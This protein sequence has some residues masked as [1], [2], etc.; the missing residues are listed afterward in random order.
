MSANLPSVT[1]FAEPSVGGGAPYLVLGGDPSIL[2]GANLIT[3]IGR[4]CAAII[5]LGHIDP[6]E[7][8]AAIESTPEPAIPIA[9]MGNNELVRRDFEAP[10]L[11]A[12]SLRLMEL[13]FIPIWHR[14]AELP[15]I[16]E[17]GEREELTILRLAYSRDTQITAA[18]TPESRHLVEYPLLGRLASHRAQL[19]MLAGVDLLSRAHFTRTHA[20]K[21]CDSARLHVYEACPACGSSDLRE[22]TIV[23]HYRCGC[24][25]AESHFT[26]G[27]FL[28]CPKCHR[29][30]RHLGVDYG[31]PG[32]AVVCATCGATTSQP[33]IA[34]TCLDC[35]TITPAD[36]AADT[37]W[38]HYDLASDGIAAL[39]LGR[40]PRFDIA[41]ILNGH[42]HIYSPQE[43]RLLASHQ[44]MVSERYKRPFSVARIT[45]LNL[46][47]LLSKQGAVAADE[48]F[49]S[50]A[51]AVIA[52]L[53]TAD[54]VGVD[55][56]LS[57]VIGFPET[58]AKSVETII[59]RIRSTVRAN[60][61]N[62]FAL[63][64][65]IA[66]GDAII[67]LLEKD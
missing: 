14:L 13:A 30:L 52:D 10:G 53:R 33:S 31:K 23:H 39:R 41:P 24:Q 32:K 21:K 48:G 37:D 8:A 29:A 55:S 25:E 46:D 5:L 64:V 18:L 60:T 9:D 26:Q 42:T 63:G 19:E 58:P 40:L 2:P 45:V 50:V 43:F 44:V 3:E 54:F 7:L 6:A 35:L 38:Y 20:C 12:E 56:R 61:R 28:I 11:N 15:F 49:R 57:C 51:A 67:E 34:F 17:S 59:E 22:E 1:R 62:E 16:A 27:S 47:A 4:P 66:E 65:Q 36:D